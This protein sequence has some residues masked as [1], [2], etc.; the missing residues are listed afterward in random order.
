MTHEEIIELAP[1]VR[2]GKHWN[3]MRRHT[4]QIACSK[5]RFARSKRGLNDPR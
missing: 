4:L 3:Q 2:D 5:T 1:Q